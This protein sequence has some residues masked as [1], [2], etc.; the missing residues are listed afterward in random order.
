MALLGIS[1][2]VVSFVFV[3]LKQ[4]QWLRLPWQSWVGGVG[5]ITDGKENKTLSG[6]ER[7]NSEA[8]Q[9]GKGASHGVAPEIALQPPND[10]TEL[11]LRGSSSASS[12]DRASSTLRQR[13]PDNV[14]PSTLP[15]IQPPTI[16]PP[17]ITS[18]VIQEPESPTTP[19]AE[20]TSLSQ[21]VPSLFLAE[22]SSSL[23]MPPPPLPSSRP[24][25][26]IPA[27]NQYPAPNSAQRARGPTPNRGP[28]AA[29]SSSSSSGLAP[30]PTHSSKPAKPSRQ[31]VLTPGHSPLDWARISGPNSDLRGVPAATPYLR[32]TPSMLKA[33]TGRKGKDAWMAINGKV[34]NV[35][36][37][38]K[39]HPG[40]VPELM[41][42]AGRDGTKL[43]GEIHPWVNYETMLAA[44][45]VGLLVEEPEGKESEMDR[46]D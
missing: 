1:L 21:P 43:F 39:F 45:L 4:P 13:K 7:R 33:Q 38:A 17:T 26:R 10:D 32:V 9:N 42:G 27:L 25:G 37:Y 11:D 30:P 44:C 34:Y 12:T 23:M 18:P 5:A 28:P 16:M 2:I 29:S 35:T 19:K 31:V 40:G 3:A 41:R 22:S 15:I 8:R 14:P 20:P 46:M 36:P 6:H 24:N